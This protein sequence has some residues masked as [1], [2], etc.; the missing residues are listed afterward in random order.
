MMAMTWGLRHGDL[1]SRTISSSEFTRLFR[2]LAALYYK[3]RERGVGERSHTQG[4]VDASANEVNVSIIQQQVDFQRGMPFEKRS[5]LRHDVQARKSHST[6]AQS[7]GKFSERAT[8][9]SVGFISRFDGVLLTL[10]IFL[11]SF[12]LR[13]AMSQANQKL[14]CGPQK[15]NPALGGGPL[16]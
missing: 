5:Q 15:L 3:H 13:Q 7:P 9:H 16:L 10:E 14:H 11:T 4:D 12:G 1:R 6:N 2:D 8:C